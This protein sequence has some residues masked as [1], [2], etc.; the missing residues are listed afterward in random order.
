MLDAR[1]AEAKKALQLAAEISQ[2][3]YGKKLVITYSGG[4]DSDVMLTL[5]VDVLDAREF[6]VINHHTS[7]DAPPTV[8]HIRKVFRELRENGIEAT[9][10]Y[11]LDAD[12][13]QLNMT[14]LIVKNKYP[15]TRTARYCCKELK[16]SRVLNRI[17]ALGVRSDESTNRKG[18]DL[19]A[20]R[21]KDGGESKLELASFFRLTM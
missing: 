18:R 7:V 13:K 9:V 16:E 8:K 12:G 19:F 2:R 15:P 21:G 6:E 17:C 10:S 11:P 5:A 4:K 20:T 14:K 3:F 1:I